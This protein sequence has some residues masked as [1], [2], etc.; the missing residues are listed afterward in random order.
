LEEGD[1]KNS[2][3]REMKQKYYDNPYQTE[4][5]EAEKEMETKPKCKLCG[6]VGEDKYYFWVADHRGKGGK[7]CHM[8]C[9]EGIKKATNNLGRG[10]G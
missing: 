1:Q 7:L 4:V 6:K 8:S 2:G 5:L 3:G 10:N 9:L